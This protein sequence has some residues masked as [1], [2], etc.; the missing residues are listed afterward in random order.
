MCRY[1]APGQNDS[2]RYI[3]RTCFGGTDEAFVLSGSEECTVRG[4]FQSLLFG[5]CN[6]RLKFACLSAASL[7]LCEHI[8]YLQHVLSV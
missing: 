6:L 2:Q 3:I 7:T 1:K 4:F 8:S 5:C